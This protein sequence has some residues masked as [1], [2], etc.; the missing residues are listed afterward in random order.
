[1]NVTGVFFRAPGPK[2]RN[3]SDHRMEFE[4]PN[5]LMGNDSAHKGCALI[6]QNWNPF[7]VE[8]MRYSVQRFGEV[9]M[10]IKKALMKIL[11][12][13]KGILKKK[14]LSKNDWKGPFR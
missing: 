11:Q 6:F 1:M 13:I 14:P 7:A 3:A 12:K 2:G 10:S 8:P 9:D 4:G 5:G